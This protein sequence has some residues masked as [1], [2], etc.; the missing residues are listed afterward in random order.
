M[1]RTKLDPASKLYATFCRRMARFGIL[2]A[3]HDGPRT[4][5]TAVA[6]NALLP[7]HTKVAALRFL[8]G[9]EALQYGTVEPRQR[10]AALSQLHTLLAACR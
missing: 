2:R 6:A 9:Y 7:E 10:R 5:M 8:E 3:A 4:F 1:N